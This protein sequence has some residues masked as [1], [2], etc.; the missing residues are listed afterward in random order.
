MNEVF[1]ELKRCTKCNLPETYPGIKFD[2]NEA[3]IAKKEN[4]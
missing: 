2:E 1:M 3:R 4:K